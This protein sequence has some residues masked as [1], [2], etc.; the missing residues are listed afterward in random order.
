[1]DMQDRWNCLVNGVGELR[2]M[3]LQARLTSVVVG[4]ESIESGVDEAWE[5]CH[6]DLQGVLIA[7]E[8]HALLVNRLRNAYR[9]FLDAEFYA[10]V[11]EVTQ[12]LRLLQRLRKL[13]GY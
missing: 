8:Q 10:A 11:W 4:A 12:A 7:Q 5:E 3:L 9:Y 1:M 2:Q 13:Q 6:E